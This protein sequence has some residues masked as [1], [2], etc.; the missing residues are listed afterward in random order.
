MMLPA[1]VALISVLAMP[2]VSVKGNTRCPSAADVGTRV[3]AMLP[4]VA[5]ARAPDVAELDEIDRGGPNLRLTLRR[6]DGALIGQRLLAREYSCA[7]LAAAAA[8]IIATW[9]SDVHPEFKPHLGSEAA[10]A[11]EAAGHRAE[12]PAVPPSTRAPSMPPPPI[13]APPVTSIAEESASRPIAAPVAVSSRGQSRSSDRRVP[14]RRSQPPPQSTP[15]S[16]PPSPAPPAAA[17]VAAAPTAR[18]AGTGIASLSAGG[19]DAKNQADPDPLGPAN[20][21]L[22]TTEVSLAMRGAPTPPPRRPA[23]VDLGAALLGAIAPGAGVADAGAGAGALVG[24]AWTHRRSGL[25]AHLRLSAMT[26]RTTPLLSGSVK[27]RRFSLALGPHHRWT[28]PSSR[29]LLD[30]HAAGVA[31]LL[32]VRGTNFNSNQDDRTLDLG[33]SAGGR[34]ALGGGRL[35]PWVDLTFTGWPVPHVVYERPADSGKQLPRFET[36]LAVGVSLWTGN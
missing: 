16:P 15:L 5:T 33:F 17:P 24:G 30:V 13:A 23:A 26:E 14:A 28:F 6:P 7:E 1:C 25:G 32:T 4:L 22:G 19:A 21:Q 34:L 3:A 2:A 29:L 9:E 8:V 20:R 35:R 18:P 36:T 11:G 27:W 10:P 12:R 31:A